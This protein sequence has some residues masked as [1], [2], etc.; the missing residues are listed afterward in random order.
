MLSYEKSGYN[1]YLWFKKN[2]F[3]GPK[4]NYGCSIPYIC[5]YRKIVAIVCIMGY[6]GLY[7]FMRNNVTKLR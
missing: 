3:P 6:I 2:Q 1:N 4:S 5:I 7:V